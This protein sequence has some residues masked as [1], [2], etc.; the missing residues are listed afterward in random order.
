MCL[1]NY[2][3]RTLFLKKVCPEAS[4]YSAQ[5]VERA[6]ELLLVQE[7]HVYAVEWSTNSITTFVDDMQVVKADCSGDNA[8]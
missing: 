3:K 1:P 8:W 5:S 4:L 7:F 6:Y 2:D